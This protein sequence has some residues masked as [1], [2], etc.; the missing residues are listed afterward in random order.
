M[1]DKSDDVPAV[2]EETKDETGLKRR[3]KPHKTPYGV[4]LKVKTETC[5]RVSRQSFSGSC[6]V[7]LERL[8]STE[9][10]LD[11]MQT[12]FDDLG[13]RMNDWRLQ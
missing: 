5:P 11:S 12:R 13:G 4:K 10:R 3:R 6:P 1:S 2:V 7:P 9:S 8:I